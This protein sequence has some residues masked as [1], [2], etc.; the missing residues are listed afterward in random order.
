MTLRLLDDLLDALLPPRCI[1][2]GSRG[3]AICS[4]CAN[5]M[6]SAPPAPPPSPLAWWTACYA[7]DGVARELVARAKYRGEHA[8]LREL[9][10]TLARAVARVAEEIDVV[11]WAPASSARYAR[12]G[13]DH[14]E[15]LAR[16]VAREYR[17]PATALLQ[18]IG[19]VAQTGR[20][21]AERRRGPVV[22]ATR[23]VSGRC[24]LVVDDVA[25]TG[26]TLA[27]AA[28]ALRA[29]GA[30]SVYAA[31][32]ART[33]APGERSVAAAYTS[34]QLVAPR[35]RRSLGEAW[36]SLSWASTRKSTQ[37]FEGSPS[38]SSNG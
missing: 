6:R 5:A 33:P 37:L 2:C 28:R 34:G 10:R 17:K 24:V 16:V 1:A 9:G 19:G 20:G 18:R 22:R 35:D 26:G 21:A 14:A 7:Y 11:T 3:S 38:K 30:K 23:S 8:V 27:A 25:T 13:V 32:L 36:T 31:T 29:E 12:T 15:V 4:R